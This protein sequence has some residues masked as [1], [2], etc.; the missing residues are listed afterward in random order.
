VSQIEKALPPLAAGRNALILLGNV[1]DLGIRLYVAKVFFL[2]G[3][4]KI[5]DWETTVTLFREEYHVPV[6]P[7]ELAAFMG[8]AGELVLPVL[9]AIGLATRFAALGLTFVNI[10]AVVSYRHVLMTAEPALAQHVYWGVLILVVLLH[11]PG[12]L[13]LD[14]ILWKRMKQN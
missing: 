10:M 12:K 5:R 11:G 6:L 14:A 4:T 9:L 2:S 13:S 3:L 1:L 7:P 8:T